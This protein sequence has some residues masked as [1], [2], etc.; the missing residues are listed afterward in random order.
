MGSLWHPF[1]ISLG[2]CWDHVGFILGIS[3]RYFLESCWD[4]IGI[5]LAS[6]WDHVGIILESVWL[7]FWDYVERFFGI[8]LVHR[9][10]DAAAYGYRLGRAAIVG[11]RAGRG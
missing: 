1:G 4:H 6:V 11:E 10:T 3:L 5:I 7:H 2:L 9:R 8:I